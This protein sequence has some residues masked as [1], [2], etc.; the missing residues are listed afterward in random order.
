MF[1]V[2]KTTNH[3]EVTPMYTTF[4]AVKP[5]TLTGEYNTHEST[6]E[7]GIDWEPINPYV[8]V[9]VETLSTFIED[10][11]ESQAVALMLKVIQLEFSTA[12]FDELIADLRSE[13]DVTA[14]PY[15]TLGWLQS[16]GYVT[17]DNETA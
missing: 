13:P 3:N 9:P 6:Q 8:A 17:L 1:V 12:E 15:A 14:C 16:A 7:F 5:T 2:E 11:D 10:Y 4:P